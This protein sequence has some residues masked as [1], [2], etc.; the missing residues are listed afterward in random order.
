M[1]YKNE[2]T[3]NELLLELKR[4]GRRSVG[5]DDLKEYY[6]ARN[7]A[8]GEVDGLYIVKATSRAADF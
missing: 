1:K 7:N 8:L 6:E 5:F 4:K 2:K 3:P